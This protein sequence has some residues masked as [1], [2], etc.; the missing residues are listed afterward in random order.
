M[1]FFPENK[2]YSLKEFHEE[3]SKRLSKA[4]NQLDPKS[5]DEVYLQLVKCVKNNSTIFSCGNGGSS[6]IAEHLACDFVKGVSTDSETNPKVFPLLSTPIL[7]AIANDI[8]YEEV[9][10]FQVEKYATENDILLSVSSSGNSE[11]VVKAI[12]KA[13]SLNLFT[14]SFVAFDGGRVKEISDLAIHVEVDNYGLAEDVHHALMHIFAQF[15][16]L[17]SI[18]KKEKIGKIKF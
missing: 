15:L 16:R 13:K 17:Q 8:S 12:E 18:S 3:Y 11:N 2:G 9:F 4:L 5:L 6:S 14:I 10:A 1:A 7:T